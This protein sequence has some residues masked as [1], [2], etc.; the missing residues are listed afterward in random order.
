MIIWLFLSIL[1][2]NNGKKRQSLKGL[3]RID[4]ALEWLFV[5]NLIN[6]LFNFF[7]K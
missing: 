3:N 5:N 2:I 1:K 4:E 6:Y 7:L